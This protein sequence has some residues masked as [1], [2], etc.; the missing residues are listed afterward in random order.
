MPAEEGQPLD[1]SQD[2]KLP[3]DTHFSEYA[4]GYSDTWK[5]GMRKGDQIQQ[6]SPQSC[7]SK[8]QVQTRIQVAVRVLRFRLRRAELDNMSALAYAGSEPAALPS[9]ARRYCRE[10][11]I[12]KNL[13]HE[14]IA[15]LLGIVFGFGP[16]GS[17]GMVFPWMDKGTLNSFLEKNEPSTADRFQLVR[18]VVSVQ[19]TTY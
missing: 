10:I 11:E 5:A 18:F 16:H 13:C 3:K 19:N 12:W 17:T 7:F 9:C 1:L 2:I 8:R 15:P 6:V 4:D 14:H